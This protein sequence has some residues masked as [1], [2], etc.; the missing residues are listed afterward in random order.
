MNKYF[1]HISIFVIAIAFTSCKKNIVQAP[2]SFTLYVVNAGI[3]V[4]EV[5]TNFTTTPLVPY[6]ARNIYYVQSDQTIVMA[7]SANPTAYLLNKNLGY[8]SGVYTIFI[9]GQATALNTI[10]K[11]EADLPFIA[12]DK[13]YTSTDSIVNIRFA[14]L[15]PNS[16]PLKIKIATATTN[17]VDDLPYKNISTWRAYKA[18][19]TTANYSLQIRDAVTDALLA[20]YTFTANATNRFKN[21]TLMIKGLQGTTTGT[22][23]FGVAP[24]NYF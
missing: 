5:Q 23:A 20:T 15:S 12:G 18:T 24:I 8:S 10:V 7:D 14:N 13:I 3:G 16:V 6:G 1:C 21:V 11:A 9:T 19:A 4:A 2:S 22:N 17:E